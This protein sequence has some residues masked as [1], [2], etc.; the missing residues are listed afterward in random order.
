[1]RIYI[2]GII[3]VLSLN[4]LQAQ[5]SFDL[6]DCIQYGLENHKSVVIKNNETGIA[7]AERKEVRA[8]YLPSISLNAGID[9]NL[10]VQEQILPAGLF[11]DTDVR[12]AFTKQYTTT[13]TVQLE[14][15]LY[16]QSLLISL[17]AG[18]YN[19]RRAGKNAVL[20]EEEVIFNIASSYY[21]TLVYRQQ[22]SFLNDNREIYTEQQ[23]IAQLQVDK[24]VLAEVELY[25]IKVTYSN[26][27]SQIRLCE[28]NITNSINGLKNAMGFPI[29]EELSVENEPISYSLD[30]VNPNEGIP[31]EVKNRTDY[32]IAEIDSQLE[33]LEYK[34]IRAGYLPILSVYG[35]YG[36]TGFGDQLGQSFSTISDFSS[37]GVKLSMPVFDGFSRRSQMQQ[38]KLKHINSLETLKL[39]ESTFR[40]EYENAKVK[41]EQALTSIEAESKNLE[42]AR[43]VLNISN[44]Q[45][46]KGIIDMNEWLTSQTSLKESQNNYLNS[47]VDQYVAKIELE[48]ARGTIKNFYQ[49]LK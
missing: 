7:E 11:G 2:S 41:L 38:A 29:S 12:V 46:T 36:G 4:T 27:Q 9:D 40:M 32:Q 49:N 30:G 23:R 15:K 19:I 44:L 48:K 1:M 43:Q 24:G 17:K 18:K 31:F 8:G 26:N 6:K 13:A 42:L 39:D 35:K 37:I 16:D 34:K 25:K 3:L 20:N 47:I 45:Y 10:Q 5:Q 22:L 28:K 14:Q 21:Q 33:E